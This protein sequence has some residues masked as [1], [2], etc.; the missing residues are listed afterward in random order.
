MEQ[1][2]GNNP[3]VDF[4]DYSEAELEK[5]TEENF[6]R[7][8]EQLP[9]FNALHVAAGGVAAKTA[10]RLWPFV[11]AYLRRKITQEQLNRALTRVLGDSGLSLTSRIV[12]AATLGP[13]FAWY[14]LARSV[15]LITNPFLSGGQDTKENGQ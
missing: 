9:E 11:A 15:F 7:L 5:V 1:Y 12:W 10:S 3:M 2:F 6:D 4:S 14:L 8:M 13:V